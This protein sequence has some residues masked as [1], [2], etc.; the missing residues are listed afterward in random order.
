M[1]G[2]QTCALPIFIAVEQ[3]YLY[4]F[5]RVRGKMLW[6]TEV[7]GYLISSLAVAEDN[8]V[9]VCSSKTGI[10]RA[11]NGDTGKLKWK[12]ELNEILTA[13]PSISEDGTLYLGTWSKKIYA[14]NGRTGK[15]IWVCPVKGSL[16][17]SPALGA[18]GVLYI[19]LATKT[20]GHVLAVTMKTGKIKW[21]LHDMTARFRG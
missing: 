21:E 19:G 10:I 9:F 11:V 6:R 17:S 12:V 7:E 15:E 8:T 2:V 18:N 4:A 16:E 1:T 20:S 13:S 14:L 5:D 3:G